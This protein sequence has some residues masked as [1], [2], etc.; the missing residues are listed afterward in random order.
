MSDYTFFLK[1][2][3]HWG[4]SY[5]SL[6]GH[7]DICPLLQ[8]FHD[9]Q[10]TQSDLTSLTHL[11]VWGDDERF[12]SNVAFLLV[13]PKE[14]IA[15]ERVYRLAMV[16]VHPYQARV[17]TLGVAAKQ[18]TQLAS[19]GPNCP[20][21][22]MQLNG[23]ACHVPLPKEG[24]L[25]DLAEECTSHV[26]CRRIQQLEVCQLLSSGSQVVYPEGLNGCQVLVITTL[27]ESLS[28]GMTLLRGK[29]TFLQ[30]DLS[31]SSTEEQETKAPSLGDGLI[32]TPAG[33]PNWAFSPKAEGQISMTMEVSELLSQAVLDTTGLVSRSSTPKRPGSLAL[34]VALPLKLEDSTKPVDTSSQV[35]VPKDAE[36]DDPLWRKY[37]SLHLPQLKPG[38]LVGKPSMDMAQLQEEANKALDHLLVTRSFLDAR[39]RKQVSDFG[40]ALHQI[41]FDTTKAIKEA[42]T[43]CAHTHLGFGDLPDSTNKQSQSPTCHLS[44]GY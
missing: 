17:S 21:T 4:K 32:P 9:A 5:Q 24:H 7:H 13:L 12:C 28:Q 23:D 16:W 37:M 42:K 38:G 25:S 6:W 41:E 10:V 3:G 2:P 8:W 34:T 20:Y 19:T 11:T 18:L 40:M 36:M 22:F 29:S 35:I 33:S 43:F 14:G 39:W 27:P 30:V 31:Q 15:E 26:P 1:D 44:Q